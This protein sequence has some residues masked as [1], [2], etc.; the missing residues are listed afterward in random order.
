MSVSEPMTSAG[1]R[2]M[3]IPLTC[4]S[5]G[6]ASSV[7]AA[8]SGRP[9]RCKHCNHR[10][11][12]PKSGASHPETY[13]LDEPLEVPVDAAEISLEPTS[14]FVRA[15]GDEPS[16]FTT[17]RKRRPIEPAASP[18][19]RRE[20]EHEPGF[21]W[22]KWLGR[23][24]GGTVLVLAAIALFAPRGPI[25]V[26]SV[27]LAL[28]TLMVLFGFGVGAYGAFREDVLYGLLY[29]AIPFYTAYYVVTRWD[30]LWVW[31]ACS[32]V[33][34][35]LVMLGTEILRWNGVIL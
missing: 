10:F 29:L 1:H 23:V 12:I 3:K 16:V 15:R 24:G 2:T 28:G 35:G 32:T 17:R 31:F 4:P 6:A 8:F 33:G 19:P 11:T 18:R 30:D 7:D 21:A 34:V 25:L 5:C 14:T 26:G 13:S 9:G 27:L 22:G 20:R